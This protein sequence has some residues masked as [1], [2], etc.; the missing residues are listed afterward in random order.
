MRSGILDRLSYANVVATL[1]VFLALGGTGYALTL[2]RNSVGSA[3]LRSDSV[4][5]QEL[6]RNAVTSPAIR[7]R[8]VRIRDLSPGARGALRGPAGATG[9]P[10]PAGPTYA[11]SVNAI[12]DLIHGN[13]KFSGQSGVG[14]RIIGFERPVDACVAT[15]T[16]ATV[17]GSLPP[18]PT[19]HVTVASGPDGKVLIQTWNPDGRPAALPFNLIVAC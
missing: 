19:A 14:G 2:P 5:R 13:A 16:L 12:G 7:N 10:G 17:A 18:P 6:R 11:A 9:P 1:A 3:Q 8:A 4:G 15:A